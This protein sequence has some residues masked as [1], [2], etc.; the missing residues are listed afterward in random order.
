M[1]EKQVEHSSRAH[2]VL[3]ASSSSRWMNCTPSARMAE[4]KP[5]SSS[6]H[7]EQGT[8]AHEMSEAHIRLHLGIITKKEFNGAIRELKS[9]MYNGSQLYDPEFEYPVEDYVNF[10]KEQIA[11]ARASNEDALLLVEE[12]FDLREYI[13]EGFGTGDFTAV[14]DGVLYITD[15]K[16][17][18]GVRVSAIDNPQL[19]VYGLGGLDAFGMLYDIHTVR[20]TIVQPRLD[21]ISTWDI[22]ADELLEWGENELRTKADIAFKGEGEHVTGPWC[23]FCKAKMECPAQREEAM[24]MAEEDFKPQE[25]YDEDKEA[26]VEVFLASATIR[27]YLDSVEEHIKETALKGE[28]WPGLKLVEGRGRRSITDP[29]EAMKALKADGVSENLYKETITTTKLLPLGKLRK[30][31]GKDRVKEVLGH[32]IKKSTG[33]P[34]IVE[35]SDSRPEINRADDFAE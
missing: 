6:I 10:V 8:L 5:S 3:S 17:G 9:R 27:N 28:K 29:A 16:F 20:L 22:D 2:A 26:L 30:H 21:A 7:S 32:L 19:K 25:H 24:F 13:P 34:T 12:K 35:E 4:G 18:K 15:L 1:S 23:K 31:L 14:A 11:E 33:K